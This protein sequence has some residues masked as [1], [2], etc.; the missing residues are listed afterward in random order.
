M[1]SMQRKLK[2][3]VAA[4]VIAASSVDLSFAASDAP[5][6]ITRSVLEQSIQTLEASNTRSEVIQSL[7]DVFEAAG[8]KTLLV[9]TKY[10][11]VSKRANQAMTQ[12]PRPTHRSNFRR[13]L[14]RIVNAINDKHR[15]LNNEWDQALGYASGELK[16]R[17]DP[18]RTVDLGSRH[19]LLCRKSVSCDSSEHGLLLFLTIFFSSIANNF[20][21]G[22]LK[23][24]PFVGGAGYL[25][26]LFVQQA[27][28]ELFVFAYPIAVFVFAA[29]IVFIIIA[30]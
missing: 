9:R 6:P 11:Y 17:A 21:G 12:K 15:K 28:P 19:R 3:A 8:T 22:Y 24:A 14:Q 23:V 29:P 1:G 26:A 18:L 4:V 7:A 5:L 10:K 16:R 27:L 13:L 20:S 25:G 2:S 30:T